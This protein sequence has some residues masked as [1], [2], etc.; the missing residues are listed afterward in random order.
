[1]QLIAGA[2]HQHQLPVDPRLSEALWRI[3][4]IALDAETS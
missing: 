4:R 1:V 2:M 3:E